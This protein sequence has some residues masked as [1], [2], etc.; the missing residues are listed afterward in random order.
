[1]GIRKLFIKIH[2]Q[3]KMSLEKESSVAV[4]GNAKSLLDKQYGQLIDSHDV[5]IRF[6]LGF[7][8]RKPSAQGSRLDILATSIPFDLKCISKESQIWWIS[9]K[10]ESVP[11]RFLF[12]KK[13]YFLTTQNWC[14]LYKILAQRPSTGFMVLYH[15]IYELDV[16]KISIF[17]FDGFKTASF[18]ETRKSVPPHDF[19]KEAEFIEQWKHN[20]SIEWYQ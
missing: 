18:Y 13:I 17:G 4:V 5:I 12:C 11:L 16:K 15:L 7:D 14:H 9:P 20:G 8:I 19:M 6:N 2:S 3:K 1:M 10:R